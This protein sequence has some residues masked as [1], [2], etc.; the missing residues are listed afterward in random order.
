MQRPSAL[1]S[2]SPSASRLNMNRAGPG[3]VRAAPGPRET[4]QLARFPGGM[5]N[6][7]SEQTNTG[8]TTM[9][10]P[11]N[12]NLPGGQKIDHDDLSNSEWQEIGGEADQ[13]GMVE[14]SNEG[15]L[16]GD[17]GRERPE[18]ALEEPE[19]E[20]RRSNT[21][22]EEE[23]EPQLDYSSWTDERIEQQLQDIETRFTSTLDSI[24][25]TL[26]QSDTF[27]EDILKHVSDHKVTL[28]IQGRALEKRRDGVERHV[29][30]FEQAAGLK[31]RRASTPTAH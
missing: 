21:A 13:D 27:H 18:S 17:T 15:G 16:H 9:N 22:Y 31:L 7:F 10:V 6:P 19:N 12:S 4:P 26:R 29:W 8:E 28:G 5:G 1:P 2:P 11:A 30:G 24:R 23:R 3:G 25:H 14:E 20:D